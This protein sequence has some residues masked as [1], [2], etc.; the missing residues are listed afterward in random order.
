MRIKVVENVWRKDGKERK[1]RMEPLKRRKEEEHKETD[2]R[3]ESGREKKK[4]VC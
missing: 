2:E 1:R 4:L 3:T